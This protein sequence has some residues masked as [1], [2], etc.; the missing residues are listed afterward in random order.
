[1]IQDT[2]HKLE[3]RLATSSAMPAETREELLRLLATL[4][5][6][7]EELS[8]TDAEHAESIAGFAAVY[9]HEAT[10]GQRNPALLEHSQQGLASAVSELEQTHPRLVQLVNSIC[11]ALSNLGI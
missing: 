10:R 8:R 1:M 7:V 2:I 3:A 4:K 6:E 11:T 5:T 9:A